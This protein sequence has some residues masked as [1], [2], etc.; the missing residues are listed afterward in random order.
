M[1]K[2]HCQAIVMGQVSGSDGV[3]R[4]DADDDLFKRPADE[5]VEAFMEHIHEQHVIPS[6]DHY[7]LNSAWKNKEKQV[8]TAVGSLI[9]KDDALPFVLMISQAS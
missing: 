1:A 7:E 3:Y 9:V 2:I 4:F 6:R 5:I 8:V